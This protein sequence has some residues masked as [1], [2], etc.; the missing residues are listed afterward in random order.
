MGQL[1]AAIQMCSSHQVDD[2]LQA[3]EQYIAEAAKNG[4]ELVV[5]PEMFAMLGLHRQDKVTIREPY[6][7]GPIQNFLSEQASRH[8]IWLVGGTIPLACDY[9]DKIKAACLVYNNNGRVVTRYDKMH[10]FD[11]TIQNRLYHESKAVLAGDET[12]VVDTPFGKIGLAV[13]FD[14]RFP[15]QFIEMKKQG[16][17]IFVVPTAFS[18]VTGKAHWDI[19]TRSR[20]IENFCYLVGACQGGLHT[21]NRETYGHS[22]IVDPWGTKIS[23]FSQKATGVIYGE[24]ELDYLHQIRQ[25]FHHSAV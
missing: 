8:N 21:N 4:A 13:C 3:A 6:G 22:M 24:L 17:Q 1:V 11:A 19:L 2:N 16:A 5:L 12:T 14:L 9:E 23:E 10:L 7:E 25:S 15:E 18:A 20:A